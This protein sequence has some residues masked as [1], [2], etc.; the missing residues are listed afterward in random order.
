MIGYCCFFLGHDGSVNRAEEF[1]APDDISAVD[2][3]CD[4]F[5]TNKYSGVQLWQGERIVHIEDGT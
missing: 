1:T 5:R 2:Q 3:A 4:I